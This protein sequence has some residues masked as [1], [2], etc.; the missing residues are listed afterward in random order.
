MSISLIVI[1]FDLSIYLIEFSGN[2]LSCFS[3]VN[4][5]SCIADLMFPS[6]I[7]AAALS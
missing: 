5:S 4:L 2:E 7:S 1:L 6:T 3:L